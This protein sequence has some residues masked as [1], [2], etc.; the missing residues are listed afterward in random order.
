MID[1]PYLP[2]E[3]LA[4]II[5]YATTTDKKNWQ[6]VNR[7]CHTILQRKITQSTKMLTIAIHP[8]QKN[9]NVIDVLYIKL[10]SARTLSAYRV[11]PLHGHPPNTTDIVW[12]KPVKSVFSFNE[13]L[14]R[15][16]IQKT[17]LIATLNY[18]WRILTPNLEISI[19]PKNPEE[20]LWQTEIWKPSNV[21]TLW[22]RF[23]HLH[24]NSPKSIVA[25]HVLTP[26]PLEPTLPGELILMW[27][28][29]LLR[30]SVMQGPA[31]STW[32]RHSLLLYLASKAS[33]LYYGQK[34]RPPF[35]PFGPITVTPR[36]RV[37][38][39]ANHPLSISHP[40]LQQP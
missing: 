18:L 15:R 19:E 21:F 11:L 20:I 5:D 9:V 31:M 16:K 12:T 14:I 6:L 36:K 33:T 40:P 13:N 2:N 28:D 39:L 23:K 1:S 38:F 10:G 25:F 35:S 30:I 22:K 27:R 7:T 34:L 4:K 32:G 17:E 37:R 26:Y 3:L 29:T 8:N 24:T